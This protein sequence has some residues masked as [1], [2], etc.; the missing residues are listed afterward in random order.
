LGGFHCQS[1]SFWRR[2]FFQKICRHRLKQLTGEAIL[3]CKAVNIPLK[4]GA[5][6]DW[7]LTAG[8]WISASIP[9]SSTLST[10]FGP[11]KLP[12]TAAVSSGFDEVA[13]VM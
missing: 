1:C 10:P 3:S 4:P 12:V 11:E 9:H 5:Q 6:A 7:M 2:Y 8:S 13:K